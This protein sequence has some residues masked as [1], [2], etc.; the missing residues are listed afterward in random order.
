MRVKDI[1]IIS[2]KDFYPKNI[3]IDRKSYKNILIYYL[4]MRQ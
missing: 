2:I 1:N 4:G 3:K